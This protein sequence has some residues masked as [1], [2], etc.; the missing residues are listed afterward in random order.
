MH[1]P[2]ISEENKENHV[3]IADVPTETRTV[4]FS[5]TSILPIS[6]TLLAKNSNI[7]PVQPLLFS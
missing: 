4:Y 5:D 2:R 6:R 3:R 1:I 7:S